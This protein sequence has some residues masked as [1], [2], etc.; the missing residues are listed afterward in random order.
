MCKNGYKLR[1]ARRSRRK[2]YV[3]AMMQKLDLGKSKAKAS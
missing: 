2:F 1:Y 3:M